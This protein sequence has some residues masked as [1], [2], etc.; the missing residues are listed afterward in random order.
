MKFR[1]S[2]SLLLVLVLV[3]ALTGCGKKEDSS[4]ETGATY[5]FNDYIG[6]S[7][8]QT[9]SPMEWEYDTENAIMYLTQR[10]LYDII[11]S[12]DSDYEL[13]NEMAA[14]APVDV[15]AD[16]AGSYG[17]PSDASEG[18]AYKIALREEACWDDGT[19]INAD[20]YIY[21]FQQLL[22]PD[23]QC[24]RASTYT[25]GTYAL[26]NANEYFSGGVEYVPY[27]DPDTYEMNAEFDEDNAYVSLSK[28]CSGWWGM[29][30]DEAYENYPEYWI[31]EDGTDY[32]EELAALVGDET[33][34]KVDSDIEAVLEEIGAFQEGYVEEY[35]AYEHILDAVTWDEVGLVKNDDYTITFVFDTPITSTYMLYYGF[36]SIPL[37]KE[38]LYEVNKQDVGGLVKSTYGTSVD[39]YA[40][41]G[42]YKIS[43]WQ[44][45][46]EISLEKNDNWYGYSDEAFEGQY[47]TTNIVYQVIDEHATA[48][49]LF[50]QGKIDEVGMDAND[51]ETYGT[52]DYI[53]YTPTS[54]TYKISFNTDKEALESRESNGINKTIITY[55]DFRQAFAL[56]INRSKFVQSCVP[57]CG[58]CLV[59]LN[60]CYVYD[61]DTFASYRS[62]EQAQEVIE[63]VYGS[64]DA[65]GYDVDKAKE[66]FESAYQAALAA[67]DISETDTVKLELNV[68]TISDTIT[69]EINFLNDALTEAT[70]GTSLEG[71]VSVEAKEVDDSY[72]AMAAGTADI[73][74]SAWGGSDNDPYSLTECYCSLS[75]YNDGEHGFD[76]TI[77]FT[78]EIDGEEY[79]M[80]FEDWDY[81]LRQGE[82]A[83][84]ATDTRLQVLAAIEENILLQF[85]TTPVYSLQSSA[86]L[87]QKV[88]YITY[89][90]SSKISES[91]GGIRF[92]TY[93]YTDAEWE[94]YCAENNNQLTY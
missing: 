88:E 56:S 62:T 50:L 78:A 85:N 1:Q 61:T 91:F 8:V 31:D 23:Q 49:Q 66:L 74:W 9:L 47:Q 76:N 69:N 5:T 57:A 70:A 75:L 89:D 43:T 36:T 58:A 83:T 45:D 39:A 37:V 87:S 63:A 52:S 67:G 94:E 64:A 35:C 10:G 68:H 46:K 93:N 72:A 48:L 4:E 13:I 33:W 77:E 12:A 30:F 16:Y 55:K 73:A 84:A 79:T 59:L 25:Q 90:Y 29:S 17:V 65:T 32:Y 60:D 19:A 51:L 41:Y 44:E 14:A 40:S 34:V 7:S 53:I 92:M 26:A 54:Y 15:T 28:V 86:L 20:T 3:L 80:S 22:D 2:V 21:S 38:D 81:E 11:Y 71:R 82:W 24:Y 18:Y 6:S 27:E 42:P